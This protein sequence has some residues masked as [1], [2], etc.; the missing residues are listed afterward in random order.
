MMALR[1]TSGRTIEALLPALYKSAVS[2]ASLMYTHVSRVIRFM[3]SAPS[4]RIRFPVA[5]DPVKEILRISGFLTN[6]GPS[7]L[8]PWRTCRTAGGNSCWASSTNLRDEYGVNGLCQISHRHITK[9]CELRVLAYEGLRITQFPVAR[10]GAIFPIARH[11][12]TRDLVL[13]Q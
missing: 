6:K 5:V 13:L 7:S 11:W 1:S 12:S 2:T 10:A 4:F 8:S 3:V 9:R